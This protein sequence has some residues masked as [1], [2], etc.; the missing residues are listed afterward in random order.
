MSVLEKVR[1]S[2]RRLRPVDATP[3]GLAAGIDGHGAA[4]RDGLRQRIAELNRALSG[5]ESLLDR[6]WRPTV[7]QGPTTALVERL[8]ALLQPLT[9][10]KAWLMLSTLEG[11]LPD[12]AKV[13]TAVRSAA[14][15]GP[16]SAVRLALWNGPLPRYLDAG[17]W[18]PVRIVTGRVLV[19][20]HHTA[21]TDFATGIQRVTREA[22]RRWLAAHRPMLIGWRPDMTSMRAL[23]AKEIHRACWGGPPVAVPT[24]DPIVVPWRCTYV[25]PE[26][27][28]EASR[29]QYL[30]AMGQYSGNP[31]N[32]VGYDLVPISTAE[33]SHEGL[34]PGFAGNL[35][36]ARY[37]RNIVPISVGAAGEYRGWRQMLVGT[38]LSG[39]RIE[40]VVL[41]GQ[42]HPVDKAAIDEARRRL[43]VGGLPLV[44]VI[45]SH[46][47]RKNHLTVLHAAELLWREGMDFCLAFIGGNS[48]N[49][50][51][52]ADTL[53]GLQAA[54]RPVEAISAAD[55]DLLFGGLHVARFT[56]FPSLNEGFGLPVAESLACG[57]PVITSNFGS[58]RE[59][60]DAGGG[61]L[62]VDPRD[63]RSL[64]EAMRS[65]LADDGLR[66]ELAGKA[67]NRPVRTWDDYATET[68][69]ELMR[70]AEPLEPKSRRA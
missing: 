16:V 49:S 22:T 37:A 11:H 59:I 58:M 12:A 2:A 45:G 39:P 17:P 33:T 3:P 57:T 31:V 10:D 1:S 9:P 70:E 38:G 69:T 4:R 51:D 48:W 44:L 7:P 66:A 42:A 56:V 63:D 8:L 60:A 14:L 13:R 21:L 40:P 68:W 36:A 67:V 28:A 35:A 30:L 43:Q 64:V 61:A 53:A 62:L 18:Y 27:A 5:D 34:I 47:P 26:L 25:L 19:D 41:P 15:D 65:L 55:D 29:T 46:E 24:D 20:V 50:E 23:T 32:I 54:G 6:S 52:F